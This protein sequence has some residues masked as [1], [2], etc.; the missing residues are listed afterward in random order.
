MLASSTFVIFWCMS[1]SGVSLDCDL[2]C[3][4]A[5]QSCKIHTACL[6]LQFCGAEDVK[7]DTAFGE[8]FTLFSVDE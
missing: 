3:E 8:I 7:N 6:G 5:G 4:G 1:F 2:R